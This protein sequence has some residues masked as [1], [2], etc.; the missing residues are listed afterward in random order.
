M[1]NAKPPSSPVVPPVVDVEWLD[2]NRKNVVILHVSYDPHCDLNQKDFVKTYFDDVDKRI[3]H[4]TS[5]QY[6]I[7]HIPNAIEFSLNCA[8]YPGR[9]ERFYL[10]NQSEVASYLQKL[11][12]YPDEH[13]VVY[14]TGPYNGMLYAAKARWILK[15][16]D[17]CKVSVLDGGLYAWE[18]AGKALTKE[19]T[20]LQPSTLI[21]RR[22]NMQEHITLSE[23]ADGGHREI[24]I[25]HDLE[26][27]NFI[28]CRPAAQ[29]QGTAKPRQFTHIE[30]VGSFIQYSKNLPALKVISTNGLMAKKEDIEKALE[31]AEY[32]GK[33]KTIL[34]CYDSLQSSLVGL[35]MEH[36]G[37]SA[38]RIFTGGLFEFEIR[39]PHYINGQY[40]YPLY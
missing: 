3:Q 28:D 9:T 14:S 26:R 22:M 24:P 5:V 30:A 18:K 34:F 36:A 15:V 21:P 4:F 2:Q 31:Q 11:A 16:Y 20:V 35:A 19:V 6:Q 13:I 23:L 1:W 37:Y 38:P 8:T 7:G 10:Y 39:M 27:W 40:G 12:I 29:Y 33:F 32:D 25:L 17:F